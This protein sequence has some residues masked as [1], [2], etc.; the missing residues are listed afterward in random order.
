MSFADSLQRI[1]DPTPAN[2]AVWAPAA[3]RMIEDRLAELLP[4]A[5]SAPK[6]LGSAVRDACLGR[7]KRVRP[8]LALLAAQE[9]GGEWQSAL[10]FGCAVEMAHSASLILDDLP[11]MD[12]AALRR[13]RPALHRT[14]GEATAVLGAVALLNEAY[15][16][17]ASDEALSAEV[18]L[19]LQKLLAQA[20]GF[21]GLTAGQ[22]RDLH[23]PEATRTEAGLAS[24][25]HQ[26]TGVL[27]VAVVSGGAAIAGAPPQQ[28]AAAAAFASK[29]G[30]AFQIL[31]DLQDAT[32]SIQ[33]LG[34]DAGQDAG[35]TTFASLWGVERARAALG[36]IFEEAL[37]ELGS[38]DG[39]LA[40]YALGLFEHAGYSHP[41]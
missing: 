16:V 38:R 26:K 4:S 3:R 35:R 14:F 18:R 40:R 20:V 33:V 37:L 34:K 5:H 25:N 31:D 1:D 24:L 12:D 22:V 36:D 17:I 32:A 13:G 9:F 28:Q 7:G 15:A 30:V 21:D 23:D 8:L 29:L 11:C 27:F 19:T 10:N 39:A 6:L 2:L 41:A